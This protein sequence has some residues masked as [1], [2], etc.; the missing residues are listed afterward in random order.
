MNGFTGDLVRQ[1]KEIV[2]FISVLDDRGRIV[3][4]AYIRRK[5]SL[6]NNSEV[7]VSIKSIKKEV[8]KNTN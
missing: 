6:K 1:K 5:L 4:P 2:S 3:I 7:L 8:N